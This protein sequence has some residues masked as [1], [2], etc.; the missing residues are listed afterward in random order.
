MKE[1]KRYILR[2]KMFIKREVLLPPPPPLPLK[3]ISVQHI[4][5]FHNKA[6][7]PENN[8]TMSVI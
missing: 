8:V 3:I 6:K 7:I 2:E 4:S 5:M 1:E